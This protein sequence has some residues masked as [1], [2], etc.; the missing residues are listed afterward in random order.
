MY[1][2]NDQYKKPQ[3]AKSNNS[4]RTLLSRQLKQGE[5]Q[6]TN[7]NQSHYNLIKN[8]EEKDIRNLS[9]VIENSI[10][11][12]MRRGGGHV[13]RNR[14]QSFKGQE[15]IP[16]QQEYDRNQDSK[17]KNHASEHYVNHIRY[18]I[19]SID[20]NIELKKFIVKQT[21]KKQNCKNRLQNDIRIFMDDLIKIKESKQPSSTSGLVKQKTQT[22]FQRKQDE[23]Q[24]VNNLPGFNSTKNQRLK[25]ATNYSSRDRGLAMRR[26]QLN[27]LNKANTTNYEITNSQPIISRQGAITSYGSDIQSPHDLENAGYRYRNTK[28][29]QSINDQIS[30]GSIPNNVALNITTT[31]NMFDN[32]GF[33]N[34][35][36]GKK[37]PVDKS[38]QLRNII[39]QCDNFKKKN[40]NLVFKVSKQKQRFLRMKGMIQRNID[41]NMGDRPN[42]ADD[43][44]L[45]QILSNYHM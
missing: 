11:S 2:N 22:K 7:K 41:R 5:D 1:S 23:N 29:S 14:H 10:V 3:T 25:S 9:K 45:M 35:Y 30:Q 21:E 8:L 43:M 40:D 36:K 6:A 34:I 16:G 27:L 17:N 37:T 20:T 44:E 31:A 32:K 33:R 28:L 26:H 12:Q 15:D 42:I 13:A 18:G 19:T 38:M 39:D 24:D 4:R